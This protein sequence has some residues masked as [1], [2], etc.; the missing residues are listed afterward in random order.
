[1]KKYLVSVLL[2]MLL[3]SIIAPYGTMAAKHEAKERTMTVSEF[4]AFLRE[5]TGTVVPYGETCCDRP[6]NLKWRQYTIHI[7]NDRTSIC[8][9]HTIWKDQYCTWCGSIWQEGVYVGS[10]PGCGKKF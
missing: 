3:V 7:I 8:V 4:N 9:G 6:P 5:R 1:M 2:V 10:A